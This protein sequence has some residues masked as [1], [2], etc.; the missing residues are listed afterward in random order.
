[1]RVVIISR[2]WNGINI[3]LLRNLK[4]DIHVIIYIF[5]TKICFKST[6][7]DQLIIEP[8][9]TIMTPTSRIPLEDRDINVVLSNIKKKKSQLKRD[10]EVCCNDNKINAIEVI[11]QEERPARSETFSKNRLLSKNEEA[12]TRRKAFP[13]DDNNFITTREDPQSKKTIP[14]IN[15]RKQQEIQTYINFISRSTIYIDSTYPNSTIFNSRKLE[16]LKKAFLTVGAT[17]S[18]FFNQDCNLIISAREFIKR[19]SPEEPS[20][21]P[22]HDIFHHIDG[23]EKRVWNLSK[24]VKILK[25]IGI[26]PRLR[27]S[28]AVKSTTD[29]S[30]FTN[31][32]KTLNN[33]TYI[34]PTNI[35]RVNHCEKF[36]SIAEISQ[37]SKHSSTKILSKSAYHNANARTKLKNL[38]LQEK[39]SQSFKNINCFND[40]FLYSYDLRKKYRAI[41]LREWKKSKKNLYKRKKEDN[42][43]QNSNNSGELG[44]ENDL[45]NSE[46]ESEDEGMPINCSSKLVYPQ[47]YPNVRGRSMFS[48]SHDTK[49]DIEKWKSRKNLLHNNC[50]S[51]TASSSNENEDEDDIDIG[52]QQRDYLKMCCHIDENVND[53]IEDDRN[54]IFAVIERSMTTSE[55][56]KENNEDTEHQDVIDANLTDTTIN[57]NEEDMD[58][59][60]TS[61]TTSSPIRITHDNIEHNH[62]NNSNNADYNSVLG[63][64]KKAFKEEPNEE[65]IDNNYMLLPFNDDADKITINNARNQA[66]SG[67]LS[68]V[69][70]SNVASLS[71]N[72]GNLFN[73]NSGDLVNEN[74]RIRNMKRKLIDMEFH[75][76]NNTNAQSKKLKMRV[77]LG[78]KNKNNEKTLLNPSIVA[79]IEDTNTTRTNKKI[80]TKQHDTVTG[81]ASTKGTSIN[82]NVG[83]AKPQMVTVNANAASKHL[84]RCENCNVYFSDFQKHLTTERHRRYATNDRNFVMIDDFIKMLN[85]EKYDDSN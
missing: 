56:Q 44:K 4:Q 45:S 30:V 48:R 29:S 77:L 15:S 26:I 21:Y 24:S 57:V 70:S 18:P 10:L 6:A 31:S 43:E 5:L 69:N 73:G 51:A 14:D 42:I 84:E 33:S 63:V 38:L 46:Y 37:P 7:L 8:S 54:T 58:E 32:N 53:M 66:A 59:G 68:N 49:E 19:K 61:S 67:I 78:A 16:I 3:W 65:D 75:L 52:K 39:R 82:F 40:W 12:L 64:H 28:T 11:K 60:V 23:I 35:Q 76:N 71:T 25:H 55:W 80:V 34:P 83:A 20:P 2:R 72:I 74:K 85:F 79:N 47:L 9:I 1:M 36:I 27:T 22:V 13:E 62:N 81:E 50:R 41:I 17:I